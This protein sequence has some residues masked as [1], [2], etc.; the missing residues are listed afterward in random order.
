MLVLVGSQRNSESMLTESTQFAKLPPANFLFGSTETMRSIR[1]NLELTQAADFPL[2]IEG[3]SGTGKELVARHLHMHFGGIDQTFVRVSC[4]AISPGLFERGMSGTEGSHTWRLGQH[5]TSI[6][7]EAGGA[8]FLD[9]I[10]DLDL[11]LQ[12]KLLALFK[13]GAFTGGELRVSSEGARIVC[14]SSVGLDEAA[15]CGRILRDLADCFKSRVRL[16]PLRER[17]QDIP[18]LCDYLAEEYARKIG[19]PVPKL[20]PCV[21]EAFQKWSWPGNIREL[22]NWIARIVIFGTEEAVGLGFMRQ[23]GSVPTTRRHRGI[24]GRQGR[25]SRRHQRA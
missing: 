4:G 6:G 10:A 15:E 22:E 1:A 16:L 18:E 5:F 2:L 3:E 11:G 17:K 21:L 20:N 14:A 23:I 13:S 9:E 19:R 7:L 12:E 8:L 24:G 25:P